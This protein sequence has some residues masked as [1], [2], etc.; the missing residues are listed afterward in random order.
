MAIGQPVGGV[1]DDRRTAEL[2]GDPQTFLVTRQTDDRNQRASQTGHGG[3]ENAN[4]PR[5]KDDYAVSG[6]DI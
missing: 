4:R 3:T 2:G 5:T 6:A 1:G